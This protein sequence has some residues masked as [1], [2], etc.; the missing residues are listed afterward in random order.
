VNLSEPPPALVS[1]AQVHQAVRAVRRLSGGDAAI[2]VICA[3]AAMLAGLLAMFASEDGAFEPS[4]LVKISNQDPLA[5]LASSADPSF[6]FVTLVQHYDGAYYYAIAR[7][8]LLRGTAHTLIDQPA[9]RYGHPLHGWLAGLLSLGQ[10]RLV[11]FALMVLSLVGLAVA[12]WATSR[13]AVHFGR[14]PWGGL[15]IAFSPGLLFAATVDTTETVGAA[16]IALTFLA[17]VN[18]KYRLATLLIVAVCLDKE[19]YITVPVGLAVWEIVCAWRQRATPQE[20]TTKAVAVICGPVAL[21]DWYVYVHSRLHAWPW[22][23]QSGNFGKP[24][25]GWLQTFHRAHALAVGTF[26]QAQIAALTPPVLVVV[27]VAL[28]LATIV[29][30]RVRTPFDAPLIGMAIITS[31]QG[32]R[33]LLYPHELIRTPA[34]ALLLAVAVLAA[35]PRRMRRPTA[36][37]SDEEQLADPAARR[38]PAPRS[39]YLT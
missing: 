27:A 2:A 34:V 32:W 8:P 1:W 36:G 23:Y 7:D 6:R 21:S 14:T 22:T 37:G 35:R 33:T 20:L 17:W 10:A 5:A 11:P 18:G 29:A 12:G 16:L 9:Y 30:L 4:A 39:V 31:M 19:Q 3:V 25:A 15:L 26:E 28:T 38:V 13:L 24:L